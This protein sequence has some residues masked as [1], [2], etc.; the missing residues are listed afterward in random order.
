MANQYGD[1]EI[2][3]EKC[4]DPECNNQVRMTPS[5]KRRKSKYC[6]R[7]CAYKKA[8][9]PRKYKAEDIAWIIENTGI[10]TRAAMAEKYGVNEKAFVRMMAVLRSQGHAIPKTK[11]NRKPDLR[12]SPLTEGQQEYVNKNYYSRSIPKLSEEM[13]IPQNQILNYVQGVNRKGD[14]LLSKKRKYITPLVKEVRERSPK[15]EKDVTIKS[16]KVKSPAI[17]KRREHA[18]RKPPVT[19]FKQK[20]PVFKTRKIET[21]GLIPVRFNDKN[22][23]CMWARDEEHAQRIRVTYGYLDKPLLTRT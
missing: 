12:K 3:F 18:D 8:S 20:E 17:D 19:P 5:R 10:V 1:V 4:A 13:N 7:K 14:F 9:M 23:T 6:S 2:T 11:G 22:K 15:G 16:R 21:A